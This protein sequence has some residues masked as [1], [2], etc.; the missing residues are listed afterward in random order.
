MCSSDLTDIAFGT[1]VRMPRAYPVY[2]GSYSQHVATIRAWVEHQATNLQLIGRAGMHRY[3]N[4]DHSMLTG[5]CAAR[6][7]AGQRYDVWNVNVEKAYHEEAA[8]GVTTVSAPAEDRAIPERIAVADREIN[9]SARID[10]DFSTMHVNGGHKPNECIFLL[11]LQFLGDVFV[12]QYNLP[13]LIIA[14]S[15]IEIA[16]SRVRGKR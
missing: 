6:N 15:T 3:N 16:E 12:G 8:A 4:Q 13:W 7:V 1:V 9:L 14:L 10:L 11:G 2:D 5:I